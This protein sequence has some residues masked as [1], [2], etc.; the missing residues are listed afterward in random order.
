MAS[1]F[2]IDSSS[3]SRKIYFFYIL[4]SIDLLINAIIPFFDY[5]DVEYDNAQNTMKKSSKVVAS[6]G[7]TL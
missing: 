1:S 4:M 5:E 6:Y 7:L 3:Y 2:E